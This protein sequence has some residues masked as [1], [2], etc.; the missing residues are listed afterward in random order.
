M[1]ALSG[2]PGPQS[3]GGLDQLVLVDRRDQPSGVVEQIGQPDPACTVEV[4]SLLLDGGA[5]HHRAVGPRHQVAVAAV[6]QSPHGP[7]RVGAR[8]PGRGAGG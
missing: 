5:H 4:E 7:A 3:G 8:H 2:E 6:D 1:G